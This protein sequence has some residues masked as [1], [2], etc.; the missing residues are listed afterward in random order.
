[1]YTCTHTHAHT[2]THTHTQATKCFQEAAAA[3]KSKGLMVGE[4][5]FGL[6]EKASKHVASIYAQA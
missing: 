3:T 6:F 5:D 1:M 2:H 4:L